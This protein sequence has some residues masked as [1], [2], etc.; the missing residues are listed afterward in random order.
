MGLQ[1]NGLSVLI[2]IAV[3]A[4]LTVGWS[5]ICRYGPEARTPFLKLLMVMLG[6][7][8]FALT[9]SVSSIPN[10]MTL[11]GPAAKVMDWKTL[12]IQNTHAV[13]AY[14]KRSLGVLKLRPGWVAEKEKACILADVETD[15][16]LVSSVGGGKGPVAA[17]FIGVCEQTK[18]FIKSIDTAAEEIR[19]SQKGA[20]AA[21]REMRAAIRDRSISVIERED[22]FLDAGDRL[23]AA[24]QRIQAADLSDVLQAGADQV[25]Q[26]VAELKAGSSFTRKQVETVAGLRQSL[27]GLLT[28]TTIVSEQLKAEDLPAYR[29]VASLDFI[30]AIRTYWPNFIPAVAAAVGIDCFQIWALFFLLV[31]KAGKGRHHLPAHFEGPNEPSPV[32]PSAAAHPQEGATRRHSWWPLRRKAKTNHSD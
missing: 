31:S 3:V 26:S 8:L 30:A 24:I 6:A 10:A 2:T 32:T 27:E 16:G 18:A 13:N 29:P 20:R 4:M 1:E 5:V 14:G 9:L 22:R 21:L 19:L 11:V 15:D 28:S 23:N 7:L 12:H 17:A 25:R